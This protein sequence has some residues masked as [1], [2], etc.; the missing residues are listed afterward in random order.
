MSQQ[1][2]LFP[3]SCTVSNETLQ[4]NLFADLEIELNAVDE[5]FSND[6]RYRRSQAYIELLD[7]IARF[8]NYSAF[9]CFLIYIQNPCVSYVATA[10]TWGRI[11]KRRPTNDA[12]PL[13]ILA[14]MAPVRFVFDIKDT[15]GTAVPDNLLKASLAKGKHLGKIYE[16]TL[17]NC[18]IQGISVYET[19]FIHDDLDSANRITPA[20]R[21]KY[22]DLNLGT[23]ANYLILLYKHCGLEDKY[24]SLVYELGH[25][26]CGHL[27]IDAHAWW[28]ERRG[29]NITEEQLEAESAAFLVCRRNGLIANSGK[30]LADYVAKNQEIPV[31]SLNAVLQA[32]IYIEGM[33]KSRWSKPQKKGR[34]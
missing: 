25:I 14:P 24:A 23:D 15:E 12:R 18:R 2:D 29:L 19:P 7:F 11:F 30:Y 10:R 3:Q 20:L 5:I 27:G 22:K 28:C 13:L 21:K 34:Y 17:H 9:N 8:P 31:F 1:L 6:P 16:N 33:G 32:V 4:K 26:F